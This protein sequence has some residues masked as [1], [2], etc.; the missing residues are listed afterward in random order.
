VRYEVIVPRRQSELFN[1]A[2]YR[3]L[4]TRVSPAD[5]LVKLHTEPRGDMVR[6]EV[7]LWSEAAAGEFARYW[8]DFP[9]RRAWES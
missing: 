5:D 8:R 2:V 1:T 4:E 7:T 9:K 3:F 6:K